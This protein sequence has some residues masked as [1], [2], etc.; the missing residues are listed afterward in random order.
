MHILGQSN[1]SSSNVGNTSWNEKT[2][3]LFLE[4]VRK[5]LHS[6]IV[7]Y[8]IAIMWFTRSYIIKNVNSPIFNEAKDVHVYN[9]SK[10]LNIGSQSCRL[11]QPNYLGHFEA[12]FSK[13]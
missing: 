1:S 7:F 6:C 8:T 10:F 12:F 9:H 13:F 2:L 5:H 3:F 11:A 4:I